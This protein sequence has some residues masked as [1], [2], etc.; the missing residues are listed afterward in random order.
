MTKKMLKNII[1]TLSILLAA[2]V[3]LPGCGISSNAQANPYVFLTGVDSVDHTPFFLSA[4][5]AFQVA[6]FSFSVPEETKKSISR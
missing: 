4:Y 5:Q 6:G 1:L 2:L 3:A